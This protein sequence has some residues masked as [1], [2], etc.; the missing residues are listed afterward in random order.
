LRYE[1]NSQVDKGMIMHINRRMI[2]TWYVYMAL[3]K[4]VGESIEVD[5]YG[6]GTIQLINRGEF[7]RTAN[8]TYELTTIKIRGKMVEVEEM[9][10]RAL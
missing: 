3:T 8:D 4:L 10:V 5:D 9:Y 2:E 6:N 1:V 7:I